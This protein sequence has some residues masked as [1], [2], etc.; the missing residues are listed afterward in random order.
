AREVTT[1][2]YDAVNRRLDME[3]NPPDGLLS[4]AAAPIE[5]GG[6]RVWEV[7]ESEDHMNRFEDERLISAMREAFG[8]VR[9]E[10]PQ[11]QIA[12][13]HFFFAPD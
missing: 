8:D 2:D 1:E 4:H 10:A 12:E 13:L 11:S 5:G 7:W 9:G 6:M 3:N